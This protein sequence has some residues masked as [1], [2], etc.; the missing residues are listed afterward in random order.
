MQ[1]VSHNYN[2]LGGALAVPR[3]MLLTG[4]RKAFNVG[5]ILVHCLF[6]FLPFVFRFLQ[7][8]RHQISLVI[9]LHEQVSALLFLKEKQSP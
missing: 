1:A 3:E 2:V 8:L 5:P 6:S 9:Q 7:Y 4:V